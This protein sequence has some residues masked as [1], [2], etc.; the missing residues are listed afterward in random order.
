MILDP[1]AAALEECLK[2]LAAGDSLT[3][4]LGRYPQWAD[5]LRPYLEAALAARL[6]A[7]SLRVPDAAKARGRE[8]FLTEAQRQWQPRSRG[9][10][11]IGL[12][13]S[14]ARLAF[15]LT[16]AVVALAGIVLASGLALP[17]DV[18]YPVKLAIERTRLSLASSPAQRLQLE[19]DFDNERIG[20]AEKLIE[21][22]RSVRVMLAGALSQTPAGE[23]HMAGLRLILPPDLL[24]GDVK[25]GFYVELVGLLQ[26]DRTVLVEKIQL[27]EVK[28]SGQLQAASTSQWMVGGI[29]VG[30]TPQTVVRGEPAIGSEIL[31]RAVRLADGGLQARSLE[32]IGI[33]P[34]TFSPSPTRF[35][36]PS[37]TPLPPPTNTR[38]PSGGLPPSQTPAPSEEQEPSETPAPPPLP[39]SQTPQPTHTLSPSETPPLETTLP[40]SQTPQV[41]DTPSASE[42]PA[43]E[44]D[45]EEER[46]PTKTPKP[47]P[48]HE[49]SNTPKPSPTPKPSKTATS[50]P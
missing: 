25:P 17:G 49:P 18:L 14:L 12:Q 20:E 42:T 26:P 6:L 23:W 40:P 41:G 22:R 37:S 35:S 44:G 13:R 21:R 5:E 32:V 28:F 34:P 47:S 45:D 27:R 15:A 9:L 29:A 1:K 31:V 36:A 16:L 33:A 11:P 50:T 8:R 38:T 30:V 2:W 43:E 19:Q 3:E 48:T 4:V 10:G 7:V 24:L 46:T 39:P